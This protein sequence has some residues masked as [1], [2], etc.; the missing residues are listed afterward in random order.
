MTYLQT[1]QSLSEAAA[2]KAAMLRENP[3]GFWVLAMKAGAFVGAGVLLIFTVGQGVDASVRPIVMGCS[4]GIAV[5]LVVFAGSE[6]YTGHTMYLTFGW[7]TRR[8]RFGE[9][10]ACWAVSWLGNLAGA[11]VLGFLFVL[12]GGGLVLAGGDHTLLFEVAA[13][14]MN[15]PTVELFARAILCNWLVCLSLWCSSR[16][17]NDVAKCI[18]IFWCL[19]AFIAAGFEHSVANMTVFAVALFADHPDTITYAGALRNLA[20]VTVGNAVSGAL[21]LGWG[22]WLAAARPRAEVPA[23]GSEPAKKES[24]SDARP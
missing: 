13:S 8:T 21:I 11:G 3:L 15:A 5:T 16:T 14:K 22:Y 6:L 4:F 23:T 2:A 18:L 20:I 10:A 9:L 7:L 17:T 1:V 24:V 19:Y 12:G